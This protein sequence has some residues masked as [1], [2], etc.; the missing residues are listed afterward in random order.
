MEKKCCICGKEFNEFGNNAR[1]VKDGT[2]CNSC[3]SRF[4]LPARLFMGVNKFVSHEVARNLKERKKLNKVLMSKGFEVVGTNVLE[5]LN[6]I[7]Y[8]N[9]E[10]EEI[11]VICSV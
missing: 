10:N 5:P 7:I 2:C 9:E 3:N 4:V 11:V 6:Q 8:K 1:P